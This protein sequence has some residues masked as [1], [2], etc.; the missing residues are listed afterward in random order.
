MS[1][2]VKKWRPDFWSGVTIAII[3]MLAVL[4]LAPIARVLML[5]FVDAKTSAFTFGNYVEV[6][7]RNYYLSGL[8]NTLFV[9]LMGMAG[10]CIL[11]VP[12]CTTR[13]S[14]SA[15]K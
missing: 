11:G 12:Q 13:G 5:S 4:L 10:A 8:K 2:A 1:I 9:G 15:R 14:Q 7:T 3:L 6:F